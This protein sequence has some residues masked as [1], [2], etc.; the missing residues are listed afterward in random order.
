MPRVK[1]ALNES[2]AHQRIARHRNDFRHAYMGFGLP[3]CQLHHGGPIGQIIR[4]DP[5]IDNSCLSRREGQESKVPS[6]A[7]LMVHGIELHRRRRTA[8]RKL[9][10]ALER[11]NTVV[12]SAGVGKISGDDA[13]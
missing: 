4:V 9:I 12:P 5:T 8:R 10:Q 3:D 2:R 6:R 11:S 13:N 1:S 7:T